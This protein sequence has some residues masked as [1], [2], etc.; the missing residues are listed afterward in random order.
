MTP[1]Q[2][3]PRLVCY[4]VCTPGLEALLAAE[5][6]ALG[7]RP[8]AAEPGGIEF[9]ATARQ[10]YAA[11]L[12]LRTATRVL[13][14]VGS[15]L[16]PTFA[17]LEAGAREVPWDEWLAPGAPVSLRVSSSA[18][19]LYHTG[20]VAERLAAVVPGVVLPAG[21]RAADGSAPA[22]EAEDD[23]SA[24]DG[25]TLRVRIVRDRVT[26]S[27]DASG[28]PLYRRGWR[29]AT[30]KAPLRETLAAAL[31]LA[32]GWDGE[33]PLVDPLCGSGTIPIEAAL[34]ACGIAPGA[35]RGF[36]FQRWP[37]F[38]PGT[39]ASVRAQAAERERRARPPAI[40]AA[41]RDPGAVRAARENA[42]RAGM[43]EVVEVREQPLAA[44]APPPGAGWL[45][46]NPP[47]GVRIRGG[48][49]LRELHATL[50]RLV[51][52]RLTGWRVGVLTAEAAVAEQTRLRFETRLSTRNGGIPV[53]LLVA[54]GGGARGPS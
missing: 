31:V 17:M 33:A 34:L 47:Y 51:R 54:V 39:W 48:R 42:G 46:C 4:A 44:L 13:V 29:L 27:L 28:A 9:P 10:L 52:E 24:P 32:S 23:E 2:R 45:L 1:P 40:V 11:N 14:R 7:I 15:F 3:R 18:S 21:R 22:V 20:A 38:E 19:R 8:G 12:F 35:G 43:A 16:A 5:L 36:A 50:G 37:S 41:D 26:V 30:A 6:R 25:P 53:R 49:E